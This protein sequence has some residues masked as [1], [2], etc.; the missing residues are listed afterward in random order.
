MGVC[1]AERERRASV[2]RVNT[3]H[4]SYILSSTPRRPKGP[5]HA[6]DRSESML[7]AVF[8]T[9]KTPMR[10]CWGEF[11]KYITILVVPSRPNDG[12]SGCFSVKRECEFDR[13][14]RESGN[15][16]GSSADTSLKRPVSLSS[17]LASSRWGTSS[18]R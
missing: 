14:D 7:W 5:R 11:A 9:N 16:Y 1:A 18:N 3:A 13:A 12:V 6:H 10:Y 4:S 8:R 15:T 17:A 2:D